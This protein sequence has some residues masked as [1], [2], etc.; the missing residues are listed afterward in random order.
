MDL[1]LQRKGDALLPDSVESA[2]EFSRLPFGKPLH[3]EVKQPRSL[4]HHRLFFALVHRIAGAT[5]VAADI[6]IQMF[7]ISTGHCDIVRSKTYGELRL[8]KSISFAKMDQLA[9]SAFF[10]RCIATAYDE[11]G[12]DPA[13]FADLLV[14]PEHEERAA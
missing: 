9:F 3:C 2:V 1:W 8:P 11:W 14:P 6:V 5:G 7:K 4:Q 12:I 10:E 13:V